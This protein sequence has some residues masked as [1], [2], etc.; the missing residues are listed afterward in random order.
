M[1]KKIFPLLLFAFVLLLVP[2]S[3]N[4]ESISDIRSKISGLESEKAANDAKAVEVQKK[5]DK[6]KA[7]MQELTRKIAEVV[8]EQDATKKEIEDLQKQ[9]KAKNE[10]RAVLLFTKTCFLLHSIQR[11]KRLMHFMLPGSTQ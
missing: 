4:A 2:F 10:S 7:E 6:V 5:I 8:K 9:I 1:M 3:V 11:K